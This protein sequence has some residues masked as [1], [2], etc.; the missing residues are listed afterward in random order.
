V[1]FLK[2]GDVLL[3]QGNLEGARRSFE[4]SLE[5]LQRLAAREPEH[6]GR[7]RD[8]SVSLERLGNVLG[9]QGNLEGARRSLEQSLE[10]RQRLAAREPEHTGWQTDLILSQAKIASMLA[11]GSA[12]ER[13]QAVSLL[14]QA[15]A[16]LRRLAA[17]SRLTHVQ[18]HQ[19]L[20]AIE[21]LLQEL[22]HDEPS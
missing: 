5:V 3:A 19:W 12:S 1:S 15:Q 10:L 8:V 21:G 13:T 6:T 2:L 16:T 17:D 18:Q 14:T 7:Q 11:S 4:Q 22:K 20:P 9:A